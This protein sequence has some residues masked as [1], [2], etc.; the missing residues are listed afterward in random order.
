MQNTWSSVDAIPYWSRTFSELESLNK[1][2]REIRPYKNPNTKKY[3]RQAPWLYPL[4]GCYAKVAHV[5]D[6][7]QDAGF[8]APGK[9]FAFGNLQVRSKYAEGGYAY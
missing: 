2:V 3:L 8:E 6:V 1:T 9:I 5:S 7:I 4:D